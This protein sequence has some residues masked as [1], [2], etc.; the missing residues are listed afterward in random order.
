MRF[1]ARENGSQRQADGFPAGADYLPASSTGN[2]ASPGPQTFRTTAMP[3]LQ[4]FSAT[5][6]QLASSLL[7]DWLP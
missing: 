6:T 1:V 5:G 7:A 3:G 4:P 2:T